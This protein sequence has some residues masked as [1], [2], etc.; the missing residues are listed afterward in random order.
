MIIQHG[1]G[2]MVVA[3]C[4]SGGHDRRKKK[5]KYG[6]VKKKKKKGQHF[7]EFFFF[8]L[9]ERWRGYHADDRKRPL[10]TGS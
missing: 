3:R 8:Y 2:G 6:K 1:E 9:F 7:F 5:K 10:K 4:Q